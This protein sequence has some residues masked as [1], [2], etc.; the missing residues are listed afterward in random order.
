M[1]QAALPYVVLIQLVVSLVLAIL[2][3]GLARQVGILHERVAPM[4]ALTSDHGPSVGEQSP[5]LQETTLTGLPLEIGA[6]NA[7]GRSRL[8]LFVSPACP[9]CK[10]LLPIVESFVKAERLEILLVGD[11]DPVELR[12]LL[13][14][15]FGRLAMVNSARVGMSFQIGKLPY[16]VLIDAQGVI[17]AKGLVNNR[18][19]L[20]SLVVAEETGFGSIQ[21]YLAAKARASAHDNAKAEEV[22]E[23]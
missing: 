1:M 19:H 11:G 14:A 3:F 7:Q 9:V 21:S 8:L 23:A 6:P 18:E 10:Q 4:G 22:R 2:L 15:G 20:E 17:R 5:V 13:Q 16:A 12:Q